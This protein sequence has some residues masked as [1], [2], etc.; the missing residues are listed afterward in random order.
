MRTRRSAEGS[1]RGNK[2]TLIYRLICTG[3]KTEVVDEIH[4]VSLDSKGRCDAG[5]AAERRNEHGRVGAH[6]WDSETA[7]EEPAA[8]AY[9][10]R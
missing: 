2:Q 3:S 7:A 5:A 9:S 10:R 8:S 1:A 4:L 6:E